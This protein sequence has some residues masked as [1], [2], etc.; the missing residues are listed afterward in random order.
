MQ[1]ALSTEQNEWLTQTQHD[2]TQFPLVSF[3]FPYFDNIQIK[4]KNNTYYLLV[5]HF[6]SFPA[7]QH[8]QP[9]PSP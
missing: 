5:L 4:E 2:M 8:N 1:Y 7:H 9:T 6:A 3:T